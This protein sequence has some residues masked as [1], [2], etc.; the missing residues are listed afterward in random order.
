MW[1]FGRQSSGHDY[2]QN[3]HSSNPGAAFV[4]PSLLRHRPAAN[5]IMI[6]ADTS[7]MRIG[8]TDTR[9]FERLIW[10]GWRLKD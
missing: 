10:T 1:L 6:Y 8:C 3:F 2:T 4:A 5:I 7:A 9:P